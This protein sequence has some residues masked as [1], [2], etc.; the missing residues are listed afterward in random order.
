MKSWR[1]DY[2]H[3]ELA[4]TVPWHDSNAGP[5]L[6]DALRRQ[7][8]EHVPDMF[9]LGVGVLELN[10][11]IVAPTAPKALKRATK[12]VRAAFRE[13]GLPTLPAR[14]MRVVAW[15]LHRAQGLTENRINQHLEGERP[16][17]DP[18]TWWDTAREQL[19]GRSPREA[20]DT[21]S[22]EDWLDVLD[23]AEGSESAAMMPGAVGG[24]YRNRTCDLF[25]VKEAR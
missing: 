2:W 12:G 22:T 13:A 17:I 1:D 14:R 7:F 15:S 16:D 18:Q 10:G 19:A 5:A 24:R 23:L 21:G 6:L 3:V 4:F 20:W 25:R 11:V 9:W 8:G